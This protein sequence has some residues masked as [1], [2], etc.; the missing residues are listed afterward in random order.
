MDC[1]S[2]GAAPA[3][4]AQT[5]AYGCRPVCSPRCGEE[6]L[7]ALA[8]MTIGAPPGADRERDRAAAPLLTVV[9]TRVVQPLAE[10]SQ[11][12]LL[13]GTAFDARRVW[14]RAGG[15]TLRVA[16]NNGAPVELPGAAIKMAAGAPSAVVG[17]D[18]SLV[19]ADSGGRVVVLRRDGTR[20]TI[21]LLAG[22]KVYVASAD[23]ARVFAVTLDDYHLYELSPASAAEG[24]WRMEQLARTVEPGCVYRVDRQLRVW[25]A[26][27]SDTNRSSGSGRV[28]VLWLTV[29]GREGTSYIDV[30]L[31][32][33]YHRLDTANPAAVAPIGDDALLVVLQAIARPNPHWLAV[34]VRTNATV[35]M[36]R[37]P[38]HNDLQSVTIDAAANM[39]VG[40]THTLPQFTM[41]QT[42]DGGMQCV[43]EPERAQ[44]LRYALPEAWVRSGS[45]SSSSSSS[46]SAAAQA[47]LVGAPVELDRLALA[48]VGDGV[49][50]RQ[51]G[52][53]R[54]DSLESIGLGLFATRDFQPGEPITAYYGYTFRESATPEDRLEHAIEGPG[55][56]TIDGTRAADGSA[57]LDPARQLAQLRAGGAAYANDL[58]YARVAGLP[59][60]SILLPA[61]AV[62]NATFRRMMDVQTKARV[63]RGDPIGKDEF[64]IFL[65]ATQPIR[66]GDE[67]FVSYNLVAYATQKRA[68][69]GSR[70]KGTPKRR[71]PGE[72]LLVGA[73]PPPD[74]G[75]RRDRE[76]DRAPEPERELT[77]AEAMQRVHELSL[78]VSDDLRA[79]LDQLARSG[80][81]HAAVAQLYATNRRLVPQAISEPI[82]VAA[83]QQYVADTLGELAAL[84]QQIERDM[85]PVA[86]GGVAPTADL[87]VRRYKQLRQVVRTL[88]DRV[89][90]STQFVGK[91]PPI[92]VEMH[93]AK[94]GVEVGLVG[95]QRDL[96]VYHP[97]TAELLVAAPAAAG[98]EH[99]LLAYELRGDQSLRQVARA[100]PIKIKQVRQLALDAGAD[101]L[102]VLRFDGVDKP[103]QLEVRNAR[104]LQPL[105]SAIKMPG[106]GPVK[107]MQDD[108]GRV[109]ALWQQQW[110]AADTDQGRMFAVAALEQSLRDLMRSDTALYDDL[111]VAA[112]GQ[113]QAL[114]TRTILNDA[115]DEFTQV[116]VVR[117]ARYDS[118]RGTGGAVR[119]A[120]TVQFDG[121]VISAA[122][123][124]SGP[125]AERVLVLFGQDTNHPPTMRFYTLE[126]GALRNKIVRDE[127]NRAFQMLYVAPHPDGVS[128]TVVMRELQTQTIRIDR[129][130]A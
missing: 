92:Y 27:T 89:V 70:R 18:G 119:P 112:D 130:I 85:Q 96:V 123:M 24:G 54:A 3:D 11:R 72:Q 30:E 10:W 32:Q 77:P 4:H 64:A 116:H 49:Q 86:A 106:V 75:S 28:T 14:Y 38:Q 31:P 53:L 100:R 113:V 50:L 56:W 91:E 65:E 122:L 124:R 12:S 74:A 102:Y 25:S 60:G 97:Y 108:T 81:E 26:R 33:L 88:T 127:A 114:R 73:P 46:S 61:G 29:S 95:A 67:I 117:D 94:Y 125:R 128:V 6:L 84:R 103:W 101:R 83:V 35:E 16:D 15:Q 99:T 34:L 47:E 62:T 90:L 9:D 118:V 7:G 41:M 93:E 104:T 36:M 37:V 129:L 51:S 68:E 120:Y 79:F 111:L 21:A 39:L 115:V 121:T 107:L 1:I 17:T 13:W 48:T 58:D 109:L 42:A 45:S 43:G 78:S 57:L 110:Y 76:R 22:R 87:V 44:L 71:P 80:D 59:A 98:D 40:Y 105:R 52:I 66:A 2:C 63:E 19:Y 23:N 82:T 8:S 20:Q 69:G 126:D 55:G 5:L